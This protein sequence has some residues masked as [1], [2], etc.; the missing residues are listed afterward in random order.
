VRATV[1]RWPP[2]ATGRMRVLLDL[3]IG[4]PDALRVTE[5]TPRTVQPEHR[6]I[7]R[8]AVPPWVGR[9]CPQ[10]A[11]LG[12][13]TP[14]GAVRT[15]APYPHRQLVDA[16]PEHSWDLPRLTAAQKKAIP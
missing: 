16:R 8:L 7:P 12:Q 13:V 10:S 9:T 11:A 15:H 14:D 5:L 2:A 1:A 4:G 3:P 6:C